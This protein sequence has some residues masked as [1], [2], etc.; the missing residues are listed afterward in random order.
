M[1]RS[2]LRPV[3]AEPA[4]PICASPTLHS[5][6][7]SVS[8]LSLHLSPLC[9][10]VPRS[11]PDVRSARRSLPRDL[12][13]D[14]E[15]LS[16]RQRQL[17]GFTARLRLNPYSPVT[18]GTRAYSPCRPQP[19]GPQHMHPGCSGSSSALERLV[20]AGFVQLPGVDPTWQPPWP[21]QPDEAALLARLCNQRAAHYQVRACV[22]AH[23]RV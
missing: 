22:L 23:A 20:A 12:I 5:P 15:V 9:T 19:P 2:G 17:R 11:W 4:R 8:S 21:T 18:F 16:R 10:P 14:P 13:S 6:S 7:P 1:A 3:C